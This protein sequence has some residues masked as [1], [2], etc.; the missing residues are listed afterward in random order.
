MKP[1]VRAAP[2]AAPSGQ[3]LELLMRKA[4]GEG[5]GDDEGPPEPSADAMPGLG[6]SKC[7]AEPPPEAG[8][9]TTLPYSPCRKASP[10]R[11]RVLGN[12]GAI[13]IFASMHRHIWRLLLKHRVILLYQRLCAALLEI[14]NPVSSETIQSVMIDVYCQSA[15]LRI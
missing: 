1:K 12:F 2:K 9:I 6:F 15:G 3:E 8:G 7:A 14:A 4:R 11:G 10:F 5:G 13:A